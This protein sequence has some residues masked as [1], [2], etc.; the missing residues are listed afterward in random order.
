MKEKWWACKSQQLQDAAD[1][2]DMK[3]FYDGLKTVYGPCDSGSPPVRSKDGTTMITDQDQILKRWAEHFETVLNQ[4]AVFD[5][6]VLN[7]IP[8]WTEAAYL[9]QLPNEQE[10]L[11]ATCYQ[12]DVFWEVSR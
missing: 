7:E 9:D 11:R 2:H 8:Q 3:R 4:P 6:T 1:Q 12:A 10:V 5:D